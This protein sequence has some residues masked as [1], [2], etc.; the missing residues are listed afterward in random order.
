MKYPNPNPVT[1]ADIN[2]A[3]KVTLPDLISLSRPATGA[4][5]QKSLL[6]SLHS[7]SYLSKFKGRGMEFDEVRPY[8]P[9]DDV[10]SLDWRVTARTGKPHTKLYREERERPVFISVDYRRSM[11]FATRGAFKSV[12]AAKLAALLA[13]AANHHGDRV[14]GQL[15][16]EYYDHEFKPKN[17]RPAVLHFLKG[18]AD[19]SDPGGRIINTYSEMPPTD[20]RRQKPDSSDATRAEP[21]DS[22]E[23]PLARLGRHTRPGSLAFIL[24]DFR[25]LNA[26]AEQS[27][28][29]IARH[30]NVILVFIYDG[31][32]AELPQTGYYRLSNG[33]R[34]LI[35]NTGNP[36]QAIRY[37]EKFERRCENLRTLSM[38][39]NMRLLTCRTDSDPI[40]ILQGFKP[41][42]K[43]A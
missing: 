16:S 36:Q 25:K 20:A 22:L 28:F 33:R 43:V 27:L 21:P 26:A 29:R 39:H 9:G 1:Q 34:D 15:F 19:L 37:R 41:S 32:E 40:Q 18:L 5:L 3:V 2:K 24:S 10:R 35:L 11:F 12:L 42:Q 17:G 4:N 6:H 30:C 14:G 31:L 23:Q 38:Q 7:G 13:W 8:M